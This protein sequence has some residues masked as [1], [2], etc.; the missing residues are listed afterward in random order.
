[1]IFKDKVKKIF[2]CHRFGS[3][4]SNNDFYSINNNIYAKPEKSLN[5]T[6]NQQIN[7]NQQTTEIKPLLYQQPAYGGY[8]KYIDRKLKYINLKN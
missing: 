3:S 2:H 8:N 5:E 6:V 1:M 4:F 7:Y